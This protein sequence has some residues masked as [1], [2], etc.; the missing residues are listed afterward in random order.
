MLLSHGYKETDD[1]YSLFLGSDGVIW[2][3]HAIDIN[4]HSATYMI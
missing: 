1:L 4:G 2:P 3:K